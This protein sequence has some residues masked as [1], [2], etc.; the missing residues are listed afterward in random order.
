MRYDIQPCDMSPDDRLRELAAIL[1]RGVQRW[2]KQR[3][4]S[5]DSAT[6]VAR[7][8]AHTG[9]EL[10]AEMRLSVNSS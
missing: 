6:S 3:L 1:A 9:L 4:F 7:D 5:A 8:S 10:P 2:R